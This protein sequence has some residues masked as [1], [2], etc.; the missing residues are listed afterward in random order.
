[1]RRGSWDD[2]RESQGRAPVFQC[3]TDGLKDIRVPFR[4]RSA[5]WVR[6]ILV[7]LDVCAFA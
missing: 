6:K 1:L 7:H 5:Q 4:H 3:V 2:R